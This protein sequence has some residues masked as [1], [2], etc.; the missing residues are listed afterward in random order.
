[1]MLTQDEFD[2]YQFLLDFLD[3]MENDREALEK[4]LAE[5]SGNKEPEGR[6]KGYVRALVMRYALNS[7]YG[8]VL[9][10]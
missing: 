3:R 1:M 4:E 5:R 2:E 6:W 7:T 9:S 10:K 8:T